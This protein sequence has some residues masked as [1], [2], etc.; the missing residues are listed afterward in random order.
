[1]AVRRSNFIIRLAVLLLMLVLVTTSMVSGRYARYI[2]SASGAD[3]A[4][5][6]RFS[7]TENTGGLMERFVISMP[8]SDPS[9][10][11]V[12]T[13]DSEVAVSYTISV[14]SKYQNLPLKF[15][16]Q[17]G[18]TQVSIDNE[19]FVGEIAPGSQATYRLLIQ[20]DSEIAM[21]PAQ[22]GGMVDELHITLT[23]TQID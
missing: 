21:D 14:V 13:N 19:P 9:R 5:V 2:S 15:T 23:T 18:E 17:N 7:V 3:Q 4:R 11:I 6:A 16:I 1:M 22:Y 20:W 10:T 8:D 12:V